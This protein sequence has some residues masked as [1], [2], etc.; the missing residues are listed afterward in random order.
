MNFF[1]QCFCTMEHEQ[2]MWTSPESNSMVSATIG[3]A[4]STL[5]SARP[6]KLED[7]VSR[8]DSAPQRSSVASLEESLWIL[9]SFVIDAAKRE[10][11]LDG[12]LVPM[13]EHSL[14]Y[15]ES[16]YGN[17]A[18][19]LFN[20]LFQDEVI[21]QAL[22]TNLAS[23]I[24]RKE[25]RYIAL[26]W[27]MLVRGLVGYEIKTKQLENNGL[28]QKY[29]SL[30]KIFSSCIAHL[31][32][33]VCHGRAIGPLRQ[34]KSSNDACVPSYAEVLDGGFE[35][36]TRLAVA[37]ADCT[38]ALTTALTKK[39]LFSNGSDEKPKQ[40][41]SSLSSLPTT[42]VPG[43][44]RVKPASRCPEVSMEMKLLLW[45][46]LDELII[47]VQKLIAVL[48]GRVAECWNI[49][50][51]LY[52]S[53][54]HYDQY[55]SGPN[56]PRMQF[57]A[58]NHTEEYT[59]NKDSGIETIKFFLNC[60]SLL[61]GHLDGKR[62]ENTLSEDGLRIS[63]VL[64]SQ[65]N[66]AD[67]EVID[68]AVC[69]LKVVL[70]RSNYSLAGS[71]STDTREMD[72]VLPLLL[73][74]LDER[75]GTARAVVIL[76]AEYCSISTDSRC[77]QEVLDRLA[78]GDVVKRRNAVDVMQDIVSHLLERL[79]DEESIVQTQAA[80][81]IPMMAINKLTVAML[82]NAGQFRHILIF[83]LFPDILKFTVICR[84]PSLVLPALV[85]L[86]Y[87][88]DEVLQSSASNTFVA[89]LKYHNK[90]FEVLCMMFNC[91]SD[92]CQNPDLP[93]AS[94]GSKLDV[95][96][97]LKLIP[98]WSDSVEDWNL[99]VV[100]LIDKLFAE[101][102]NPIIVKFLSYICEQL[103]DA[104]DIVF[105]QILLRTRQLDEWKSHDSEI[106]NPVKQAHSLFDRLCPLLIIRLLP[107]RVFNNLNSS[108]MYG[109]LRDQ[110]RDTSG[111]CLSPIVDLTFLVHFSSAGFA[112]MFSAVGSIFLFVSV[113]ESGQLKTASFTSYKAVL[114]SMDVI[115]IDVIVSAGL[116]GGMAFNN[117]EFDDVRKLAAELS[118]QIHPQLV[119]SE[120]HSIFVYLS[121]LKVG[122][123]EERMNRRNSL[124][125]TIFR[126]MLL[127]R[128]I[129]GANALRSGRG[130]PRR[131][132]EKWL[133]VDDVDQIRKRVWEQSIQGSVAFRVV[134][135][136]KWLMGHLY[137]WNELS[138]RQLRNKLE[139][140][141]LELEDIQKSWRDVGAREWHVVVQLVIRDQQL[142]LQIDQLLE[143]QEMHWAQRTKARWLDRKPL[144]L[145]GGMK[146]PGPDGSLQGSIRRIGTVWAMKLLK[147]SWRSFIRNAFVPSR[148]ITDNILLAHET[149]EFIKK[150]RKGQSCFALK[151]D[152]SKAY[153]RVKWS[154]VLDVLSSLGFSPKWIN[155]KSQC[156]STV[157]FSVLVIG[158]PSEFFSPHCGLRQ[159][160]PLSPSLFILVS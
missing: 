141:Q 115:I 44:K 118:G 4:M 92:L 144:W 26:G 96:I 130:R 103:A 60:L 3:R 18:M 121:H 136:Q 61:L 159:G 90:N 142:R 110:V 107:M 1:D 56:K 98:Q 84:D 157:S 67:A 33:V 34:S 95:D 41:N 78:S 112:F 147:W 38:L 59:E 31:V 73:N 24:M 46:H 160:D 51:A 39:D 83:S 151:L 132:E 131:F 64:I 148:L 137:N 106:D 23:I 120:G 47:L 125:D 75:D 85:G 42:W 5:L 62:F 15:K 93:E 68:G 70:F 58:E 54:R 109:V 49:L 100:P 22:A 122:K 129:Y 57:Y 9:H 71:S 66:C 79:G 37:A 53:S 119:T 139:D 72:A 76:I 156:L 124:A 134:Q 55:L 11:P 135:K 97:V 116:K 99:L 27:C 111:I 14:K 105:H 140:A 13:I 113:L 108:L 65:L 149:I 152:M 101:P 74:L 126:L 114:F 86:L 143:Q 35:L 2:A 104:A 63:R 138:F 17:Q 128:E 28:K 36:P 87:S 123:P 8:L 40:S 127:V 21:F 69:L 77:L 89:V 19:I 158:V 155:L 81:L 30:L 10:E 150:K 88:S 80:N 133:F 50:N 154:G 52:Q 12:V 32:S 145:M 25:D 45:D 153:D 102:S 6:K 48:K 29:S 7:A 16:K 91:L 43:E 146:A 20:W 117:L 94:G 82:T